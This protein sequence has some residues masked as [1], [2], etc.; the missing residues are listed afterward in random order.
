MGRAWNPEA[1]KVQDTTVCWQGDGHSMLGHK[2]RYYVG[3]LNKEQYNNWRVAIDAVEQ[4]GYGL[5]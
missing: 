2:W 1:K 4:N 5:I 3:L